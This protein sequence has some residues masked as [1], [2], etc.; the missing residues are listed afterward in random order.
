MAID[1]KELNKL[2]SALEGDLYWDEKYRS[3]Y[4]TDATIYRKLPLAVVHPRSEKDIQTLVD[5]A[6]KYKTSL[7]ARTAGTS[8]AG[9]C[10]GEGIIID[11]SKYLNNIL[12]LNENEKWVRLQPG[13]NRDRLNQ[14]IADKK[15]FFPPETA[16]ANRAMIGGMVGNNSCGANSIVYG[17][18]RE[19]VLEVTGI[20]SDGTKTTFKCIDKHDYR[21]D[22][23]LV[24]SI[25]RFFLEELNDPSLQDEIKKQF[26]NQK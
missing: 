12:E 5:F 21:V 25:N 3:I 4:A 13:V 8:L 19:F 23:M 18:T 17:S 7:I 1:T 11:T 15:L 24:E 9:Q 26:P 2:K 20:L 14:I 22:N 6:T 10:V 16:T